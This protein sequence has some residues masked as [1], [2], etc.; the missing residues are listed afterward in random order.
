MPKIL[1][2][3]SGTA[4]S[5]GSGFEN[6]VRFSKENKDSFEIVGVVSNHER[7]GVRLR[8]DA[9]GVPFI[10][11][12]GDSDYTS[13]LQNTGIEAEWFALSGWL[14][15]VY[16]LDPARTFNI[17]PALLSQLR[18]R[19][20]GAG[21]YGDHIHKTVKQALAAGEISESGVSMHFITDEFDRGPIFFEFP[22]PLTPGMSVEEIR[23]KVNKAEHD[24]Q[25]KVTNMVVHGE[26]SW[27][28]INP[29]TLKVPPGYRYLPQP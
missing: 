10:Y 19:F 18:G 9:L 11:F 24:W 28:G 22:V 16:G 1:V 25:P 23:E 29:E 2:F 4:V 27:D 3:A 12:R 8:A 21:M 26:I 6:L 7:G 17:H 5:G 13:V 14:K 20:G 15:K